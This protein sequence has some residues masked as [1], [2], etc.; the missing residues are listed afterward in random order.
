[1]KEYKFTIFTPCY[2]G[3][4]TIHRVFDSV[5][6][7]TYTNYEWII[8]NDGSTDNSKA[9]IDR[10]SKQY[11]QLSEKLTVLEQENKGKHEAWNRAV[12]MG[13]GDMFIPADCDDS[14][15]QTTLEFFN[16]KMNELSGD[17]F[18]ES[19]FSGINVCCRDP[20]TGLA[21]GTPYPEQ[22]ME[23]NN[24]EL[25]YRY[26][27][28]GEHWGGQRLDLLKKLPFPKVRGH[29]YTENYMWFSLAL[30]GYKVMCYGAT[31]RDYYYEP[32]SLTNNSKYRFDRNT[33]AMFMN[34]SMWELR[35][36]G[37][38]IRKY[39]WRGYLQ[40]YVDLAKQVVKYV[41]SFLKP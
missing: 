18:M 36:A 41:I 8:V 4:N 15:V 14:F 37:K 5:A 17:K 22:G 20:K 19:N 34:F 26:H 13:T 25:V 21:V 27:V 38:A 32:A 7:Q 16:K 1:M 6:S 30:Q 23:S 3:E 40:L 2:N 28:Q 33:T 39:S 29:F 9:E 31:L 24:I 10:L 11:P 35:H 12:S